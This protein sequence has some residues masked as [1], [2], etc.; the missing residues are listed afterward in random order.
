MNYLAH[1]YLSFGNREILLGNMISDFVKGKQQYLYPDAVHKGI[2]L[3]RFID[4][5]TDNHEAT[6]RAKEVFRPAYRLYS[7]AFI[8]VVYDYFLANDSD[9]FGTGD[10]YEF[11]QQTYALLGAQQHLMPAR[12][13]HMFYYMQQQNWLYGYASKQGIYQSFGG[14]VKR[15]AYL[16][17]SLPAIA[18]FEAHYTLLESCFR[19][20]WTSARPLIERRFEELTASETESGPA[21]E[22][23]G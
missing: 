6:H 10:L 20:F 8:D 12:F 13:R 2:V 19:Q 1:A 18:V 7:G 14:L 22:G 23:E 9:T 21:G 11:A 3:H 4:T 15:A 5:I 17:D 16:Q